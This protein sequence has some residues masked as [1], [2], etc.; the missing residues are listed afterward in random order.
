MYVSDPSALA[1]QQLQ[2]IDLFKGLG[3]PELWS[4][5]RA[6]HTVQVKSGAFFF[7][8]NDPA[9][10]FFVLINGQIKMSQISQGGHQ[11]LIRMVTGGEDFGTIAVLSGINY[12][13]SAQALEDCLA[14]AWDKEIITRLLLAHPGMALNALR[15]L[16]KRFKDLQERYRELAT[17]R[18]ERRMARTLLRLV[19]QAEHSNKGQAELKLA[20]SRQDLAEMTGTTIYTVSRILSQWEQR[21]LVETGRERVVIRQPEGLLVIAEDLASPLPFSPSL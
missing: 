9:Q 1:I 10:T 14:V 16:A 3:S 13:L 15:L 20:L 18:V 2:Q 7:H 8:Q 11:V 12:P 19:Q 21:G 17:E 4:I 5:Y 6:G